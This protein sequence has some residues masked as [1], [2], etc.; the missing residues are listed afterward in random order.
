M[1][2]EGP[3]KTFAK[4]L[5]EVREVLHVETLVYF[6]LI[7]V[8]TFV[9]FLKTNEDGKM[10]IK[11]AVPI[12]FD[13]LV[14]GAYA[15]GVYLAFFSLKNRI[16]LP[17]Q[18]NLQLNDELL[19]EISLL[20]EEFKKNQIE[21]SKFSPDENTPVKFVCLITREV[22]RDPVYI[23]GDSR[24]YERKALQSWF[25]TGRNYCPISRETI[26]SNPQEMETDTNLKHEIDN[27]IE[28]KFNNSVDSQI[29][30]EE[31]IEKVVEENFSQSNLMGKKIVL[32]HPIVINGRPSEVSS[33]LFSLSKNSADS[34]K[35]R[36]ATPYC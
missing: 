36:V 1:E 20:R 34:P 23:P 5:I 6:L 31:P 28:F 9:D 3:M 29:E 22:M 35:V 12:L 26:L 14:W 18:A 15:Y 7:F 32:K 16:E 13:I 24:A 27:Y 10:K 4:G 8:G 2:A 19:K 17:L 30:N 21:D 25:D 11:E 33:S